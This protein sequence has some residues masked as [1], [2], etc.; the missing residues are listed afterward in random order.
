MKKVKSILAVIMALIMGMGCMS[1]AFAADVTETDAANGVMAD[2]DVFSIGDTVTGKINSADD[3]DYY[4]FT[5]TKAGRVTIT[6]EHLA[7]AEATG[8]YFTVEIVNADEKAIAS[9]EVAANDASVSSP[10]FGAAAGKY[11]V[12]VTKGSVCDTTVEY[13]IKSTID[14]NAYCEYEAN[15]SRDKATTIALSSTVSLKKY[16]GTIPAEADVDYYKFEINKPGYIYIYI[17]NDAA[18]KGDFALELQTYSEG[19]DGYAEWT[20]FGK[21]EISKADAKF[22]SPAIGVAGDT[23]YY[24]SVTGTEGGYTIYVVYSEDATSEAEF[25]DKIVYANALATGKLYYCSIFDKNDV[26][27]YS[28]DIKSDNNYAVK[29]NADPMTV[30]ADGQWKITIVNSKGSTLAGP[31]TITKDQG[32]EIELKDYAAGKYYIKVEGGDVLNTNIYTIECTEAEKEPPAPG[33]LDLFKK[34]DWQ[35][36]INNFSGW[37]GQINFIKIVMDISASLI[38]LF[39]QLG[40]K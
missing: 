11:F 39:A 1:V 8:S 2:A 14:T 25:N 34:I 27:Y 37:V 16:S 35:T 31:V 3:V 38:A 24:L 12:K 29:V 22:K 23:E 21:S 33:F 26:D 6:V 7:T 13:K 10:A 18:F 17:E 19:T 5:I 9:F 4:T 30:K 15:D 28:F 36:L 40:A 32:A 20:T